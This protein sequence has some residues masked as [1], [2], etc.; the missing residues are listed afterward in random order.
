MGCSGSKS[1]GGFK[2]IKAVVIKRTGIEDAA[3]DLFMSAEPILD[4]VCDINNGLVKDLKAL[5]KEM[6]ELATKQK[7]KE[8]QEQLKK[9]PESC[10]PLAVAECKKAGCSFEGMKMVGSSK[11][12]QDVIKALVDLLKTCV[13]N[14]EQVADLGGD[15]ANLAE[16]A[17]ELDM[18]ALG[19]AAKEKA[20][21]PL[22]IPKMLKTLK[23]NITAIKSAPDNLKQ[24]KSTIQ[25]VTS[26]VA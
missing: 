26:A 5:H 22:E 2:L 14:H 4:R 1:A 6:S 13:E 25:I 9:E 7:N 17:S 15:V 19:D 11:D 3:D 8:M 12:L 18:G 23:K 16:K 10:V 24:L 21:N 20:S